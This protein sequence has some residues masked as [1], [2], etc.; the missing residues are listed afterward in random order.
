ME[1]KVVC[2]FSTRWGA[3]FGG[4]NVFNKEMCIAISQNTKYKLVCIVNK[5]NN[6][7]YLDVEKYNIKLIEIP[8][9]TH[10]IDII[11]RLNMES[12]FPS[13]W[14][15]HD[16]YTGKKAIGCSKLTL[17]YSAVISHFDYEYYG[18]YK[19]SIGTVV[20]EK[21]FEQEKVLNK[22]DILFS[23][24]PKLR[25]TILRLTSREAIVLNPGCFESTYE[26]VIPEKGL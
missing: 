19:G 11:E 3:H 23:V 13:F 17:S 24:G 15:G 2:V 6:E 20:Q 1:K 7:E 14:I 4:I 18:S 26:S 10:P 5:A 8:E 21:S 9:E 12:I 16:I 25:E 22:A